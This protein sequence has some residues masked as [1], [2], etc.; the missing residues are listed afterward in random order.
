MKNTTNNY[1]TTTYF[2]A[3]GKTFTEICDDFADYKSAEEFAT[4]QID[5][6]KNTEYYSYTVIW[7]L[8]NVYQNHNI[9]T[10]FY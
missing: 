2:S 10:L 7:H 8:D 3:D 4:A 6:L 5:A 1:R 9:R